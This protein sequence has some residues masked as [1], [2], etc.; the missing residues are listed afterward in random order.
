MCKL[1]KKSRGATAPLAPLLPTPMPRRLLIVCSFTLISTKSLK[2]DF[3][4]LVT[5]LTDIECADLIAS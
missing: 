1:N 5:H 4:A 3:T 2:C